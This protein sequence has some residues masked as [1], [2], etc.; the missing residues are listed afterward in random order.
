MAVR[1]FSAMLLFAGL[2]ACATSPRSPAD[3]GFKTD[4]AVGHKI[5]ETIA[6]NGPPTAQWDLPDGRRAFQWQESSVVARVGPPAAGNGA[7]TGAASQTTCFYTLYTQQD[8]KTWKVVGYDPPRP[9]CG[10]LAMNER[11]H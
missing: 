2:A 3:I 4:A 11:T 10:R 9:G 1:T 8:G 5:D 7:V 6:A